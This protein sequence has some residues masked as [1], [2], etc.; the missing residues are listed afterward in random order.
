MF[1]SADSIYALMH[2]RASFVAKF[3][4]TV[5]AARVGNGYVLSASSMVPLKCV[6]ECFAMIVEG[7]IGTNTMICESRWRFLMGIIW[8]QQ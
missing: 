6:A 7:T 8:S 4:L 5:D 3:M 2:M 1:R